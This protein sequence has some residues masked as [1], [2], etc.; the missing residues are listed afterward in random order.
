MESK[1]R[2]AIK[3]VSYRSLVTVILAAMC[4][5]FT[6]DAG[7]TTMITVVYAILATIGYY[8]HDRLWNRIKWE[9]RVNLVIGS[10]GSD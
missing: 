1:K 6:A 5:T 2:T 9:T 4:W 3:A 10:T 8:C 7:R